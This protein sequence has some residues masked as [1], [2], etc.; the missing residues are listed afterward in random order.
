MRER[1]YE[2]KFDKNLLKV[3]NFSE[4]FFFKR[5]ERG[6]KFIIT[7]L[8]LFAYSIALKK[9]HFSYEEVDSIEEF[10]SITRDINLAYT[11]LENHLRSVRVIDDSI[12]K[13]L[14]PIDLVNLK[15][16]KQTI[17]YFELRSDTYENYLSRIKHKN[18][19]DISDKI[20][21]YYECVVEDEIDHLFSER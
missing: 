19:I 18:V 3:I 15:Y 20:E 8:F 11:K 6:M 12:Q 1:K 10:I 9:P 21:I 16:L 5:K 2:N 17:D 13:T 14:L 4:I 7:L